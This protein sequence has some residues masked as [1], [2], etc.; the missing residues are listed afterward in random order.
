MKPR[1]MSRAP[2]V[3]GCLAV[4]ALMLAMSG[5]CSQ[6]EP[7]T[8]QGG[9]RSFEVPTAQ[10]TSTTPDSS[11]KDTFVPDNSAPDTFVAPDTG[12]D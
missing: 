3:V 7:G 2:M 10:G 9:G 5:A 4:A 6:H 8:Y 1:R 11:T 12:G